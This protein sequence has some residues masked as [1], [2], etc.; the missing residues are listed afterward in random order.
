MGAAGLPDSESVR[1][2]TILTSPSSSPGS[3]GRGS[4]VAPK[5]APLKALPAL[6]RRLRI[7][8]RH[9]DYIDGL[10]TLLDQFASLQ[11]S[12]VPCL[13][14]VDALINVVVFAAVVVAPR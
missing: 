3:S 14:I 4:P 12:G 7:I 11:V 2:V 8:A 1:H 9:C 5:L 10:S 6:V 13:A